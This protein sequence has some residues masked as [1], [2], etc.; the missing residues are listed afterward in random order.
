MNFKKFVAMLI[1]LCLMLA[2][3]ACGG[4]Q[5][6]NPGGNE[7]NV[8]NGGGVLDQGGD[9]NNQ[10]TQATVSGVVYTVKVVDENG[11][12]IAGAFVQ[13]CQGEN[14]TPKQTAAD[15]VATYNMAEE[16]D[17][18]VK[19]IMMPAGY[20]LSTEESVFHFAAGAKDM[21]IILKAAA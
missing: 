8:G 21:T 3:V 9:E 16:A 1:A 13:M 18:E 5:G 20:A 10:T 15:G 4:N 17:Y 12:P 6:G 11:N 14:C 7:Q 19:F 2:F